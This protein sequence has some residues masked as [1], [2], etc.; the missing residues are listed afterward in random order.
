MTKISS[1]NV[2]GIRAAHRKGFVDWIKTSNPDILCLQEIRSD[3]SQIPKDISDLD[4]YKYYHLA[5]KKGYSGVAIYCKEKP[6]HVKEGI[7]IDWID[8]EGRILMV[9]FEKLRV[10]SVYVPSGTTGDV[11]QELKMSFLEDF[12][13]FATSYLS[14][15]K[16]TLICGDVNICHTEID[17]HNPIQNSTT[18]GFLPEER[19]WVSRFLETG[20]EDVFRNMHQNKKDLYSWWS[21]RAASKERNKGWRIDYHFATKE[22]AK[23]ATH[24]I[25]EKE[26]DIS[27]HA[28]VSITYSI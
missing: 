6:I 9:E 20:Y 24:A 14:D 15:S 19:E 4:F 21:Y 1:Y 18:S 11:R 26:W 25:I 5:Q 7:G 28:P 23:K 8:D 22:I 13:T 17:I 2:N 27:D 16:P 12:I 10:I 3:I